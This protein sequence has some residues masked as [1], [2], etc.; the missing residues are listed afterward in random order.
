MSFVMIESCVVELVDVL[1]DVVEEVSVVGDH[2]QCQ[3]LSREELL[4][5]L[6]HVDVEVV[7]GL[8]EDE[9]VAV[10]HQQAAEGHLLLLA[11]AEG[12]HGAVE[13]GVHLHAAEDLL[14]A[15]LE[16]PGVFC[17]R[18]LDVVDEV[19]HNLVRVGF[20]ALRQVGQLEVAAE[21]YLAAVLQGVVSML[22]VGCGSAH[23]A[24]ARE[25][26]RVCS[27][28]ALRGGHDD[29][30]QGGLAVAVAGDEGGLLSG[31][32]AEGDVF[33]EELVAEALGEVFYGE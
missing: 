33:E 9:Q 21:C 2:E 17:L 1:A 19:A 20:G 27:P 16:G 15:L 12:L 11:A 22:A 8:V 28:L 26:K 5:P 23:A 30:E 7:G 24:S 14:H 10:V 6:Y 32:D 18:A 13:Q 29:V 25:S 3:S 4:E 31:V